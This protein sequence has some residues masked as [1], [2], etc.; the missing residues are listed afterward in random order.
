[1]YNLALNS[2]VTETLAAMSLLA[3]NGRAIDFVKN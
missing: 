2:S 1:M 3:G